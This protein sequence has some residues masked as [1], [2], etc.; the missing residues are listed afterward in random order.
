MRRGAR[1][2][3]RVRRKPPAVRRSHLVGAQGTPSESARLKCAASK[4]VTPSSPIR[5]SSRRRAS[6][7]KASRRP[8]ARSPPVELQQSM[9]SAQPVETL[10]NTRAHDRG[11]HRPRGGTTWS[12]CWAP[13]M[14]T[15][16]QP[17]GNDLGAAVVSA[18]S[19]V[20]RPSVTRPRAVCAVSGSIFVPSFSMSAPATGGQ[21]PRISSFSSGGNVRYRDMASSAEEKRKDR[22]VRPRTP[23]GGA[24]E[25][26]LMIRFRYA[27]YW[28]PAR[29]SR[30]EVGAWNA[31]ANVILALDL[32]WRRCST[33][34][35]G[36][37]AWEGEY[38]R[39]IGENL[40]FEGAQMVLHVRAR[41]GP[42]AP[43]GPPRETDPDDWMST[44]PNSPAPIRMRRAL[45]DRARGAALVRP[46]RDHRSAGLSRHALLAREDEMTVETADLR[47]GHRISRVIKGGW[48]LAGDHGEVRPA[49]AISDMEA[50]LDAGITTFDCAD[51]IKASRI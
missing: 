24:G 27:P 15:R 20:S 22:I 11:G 25:A 10:L 16:Q 44:M 17:A 33:A 47:P 35:A 45:P 26:V 41:R 40:V 32:R 13:R 9:R 12:G 36:L 51:I 14:A 39:V 8:D 19:K 48:Q 46:C 43:A 29:W 6:S 18:M 2:H 31:T 28:S 4:M 34:A 23:L 1:R 38:F 3:R 30:P 7:C 42:A 21:D 5:P 50:F 37:P 49:Q